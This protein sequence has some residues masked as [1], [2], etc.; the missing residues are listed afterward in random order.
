MARVMHGNIPMDATP[1]PDDA[2]L[3]M[4]EEI[5]DAKSRWVSVTGDDY[6]QC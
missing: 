6:M 2:E 4:R 1:E 3:R 5:D